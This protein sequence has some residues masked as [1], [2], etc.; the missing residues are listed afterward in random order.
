[1][2]ME[3]SQPSK[4][5]ISTAIRVN[6]VASPDTGRRDWETPVIRHRRNTGAGL[7]LEM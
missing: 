1:M 5:R 6:F 3:L 2:S 4:L 7:H